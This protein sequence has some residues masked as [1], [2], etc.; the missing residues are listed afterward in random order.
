MK[1]LLQNQY[2][3]QSIFNYKNE[4]IILDQNYLKQPILKSKKYWV[5]K[6]FQYIQNFGKVLGIGISIQFQWGIEYWAINTFKKY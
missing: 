5:L 4:N 2:L 3:I 1:T 6:V